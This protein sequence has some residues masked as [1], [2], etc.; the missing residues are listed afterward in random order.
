MARR[1]CARDM[2]FNWTPD[3]IATALDVLTEHERAALECLLSF[4]R[5][6]TKPGPVRLTKYGF[7]NLDDYER[8]LKTARK[9]AGAYF[10]D[11]GIRHVDDLSFPESD[12]STEGRM[13]VAA[14]KMYADA[15]A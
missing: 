9:K 4:S 2:L 10:A 13:Q 3:L 14:K 8:N 12:R 1:G 11:M 7:K 6:Q 15:A 5:N